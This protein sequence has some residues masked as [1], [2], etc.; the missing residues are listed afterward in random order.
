MNHR[1]RIQALAA[2]S[3][4]QLVAFDFV[5]DFQ[6]F[7][8]YEALMNPFNRVN[9][10][11]VQFTQV[12]R[13][14]LEP[15]VV[16]AGNQPTRHVAEQRVQVDV[17]VEVIHDSFGFARLLVILVNRRVEPSAYG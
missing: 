2:V 17:F 16:S 15:E 11:A 10:Q 4:P 14:Q 12:F 1:F 6:R 13:S 7:F 3:L 5:G 9:G 8:L